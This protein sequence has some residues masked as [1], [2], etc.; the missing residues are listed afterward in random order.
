ME[1]E[2][3]QIVDS[4]SLNGDSGKFQASSTSN[5]GDQFK[6]SKDNANNKPEKHLSK[7]NSMIIRFLSPLQIV[8]STH[9]STCMANPI[10]KVSS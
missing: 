5:T 3:N 9:S 2:V 10:S 7:Y 8:D 6:K 4:D 1:I